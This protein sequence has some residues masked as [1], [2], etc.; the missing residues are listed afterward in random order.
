VNEQKQVGFRPLVVAKDEPLR[1]EVDAFVECVERRSRPLV[2]GEDAMRALEVALS[3]QQQME[4]HRQ[5]VARTIATATPAARI[6]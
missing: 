4:K 3:I 6:P 2:T 1:L 5:V